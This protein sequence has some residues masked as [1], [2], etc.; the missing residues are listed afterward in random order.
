MHRSSTI[1]VRRAYYETMAAVGA[2]RHGDQRFGR[3]GISNRDTWRSAKLFHGERVGFSLTKRS[4]D[5][6]TPKWRC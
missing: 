5:R 6:G 2:P 1:E 3:Y 4:A